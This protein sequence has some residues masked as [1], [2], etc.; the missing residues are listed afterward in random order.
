MNPHRPHHASTQCGN[1]SQNLRFWPLL[2]I[3]IVIV[4]AVTATSAASTVHVGTHK[5]FILLRV[6]DDNKAFLGLH[7]LL[8]ISHH[9]C[10]E[11]SIRTGG[12]VRTRQ[13]LAMPSSDNPTE[14]RTMVEDMRLGITR[15]A[16]EMPKPT[17]FFKACELLGV[18]PEEAVWGSDVYSFKGLQNCI[19]SC[20][21]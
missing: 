20:S 2:P 9:R 11:T 13:L 19:V 4:A 8:V 5:N 18:K 12:A 7:S 3:L 16:A 6:L 21:P 1:A 15:V 14:A 17:I 10:G